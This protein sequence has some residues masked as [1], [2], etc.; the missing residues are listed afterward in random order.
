MTSTGVVP[1]VA[2]ILRIL[3]DAS[4]EGETT[5][6]IARAAGLNRSTTHR[7]LA[8]LQAE[9]LVD[10]ANA[11][12]RWIIGP[13][14]FLLSTAASRR[15]QATALALP[16]VRRLAAA[17]GESAFYS[18]LRGNETVCLLREDGSFPLRSHV[19]HQGLRL[20]LGVASAGLA[21]LAFLDGR[22]IE[23]YLA[24]CDLVPTYGEA[25]HATELRRRL[26]ATR[27]VGYAINPGLLVEGSWGLGAAIFGPGGT[28]VGALS[29]TGV[30]HRFSSQRRPELGRRLMDAAHELSAALA[31]RSPDGRAVP[32]S[33]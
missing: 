17:T 33:R 8:D 2:H 10:R 26:A 15:Y 23:A 7:L 5:S 18:V 29:L 12:S 31:N 4:S 21:V 25:H 30:A 22:F 13:E 1:K 19:L 27:K 20:P 11:S 32:G 6:H 24:G 28:P 14:A 3:G 9:G 16:F